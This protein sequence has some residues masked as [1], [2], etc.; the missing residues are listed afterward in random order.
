MACPQDP[1]SKTAVVVEVEV[2]DEDVAV[3]ALNFT[4]HRK[5]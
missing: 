5:R 3:H 1:K 4:I 2:Q